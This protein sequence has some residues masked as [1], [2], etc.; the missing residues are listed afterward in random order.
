MQYAVFLPNFGPFGDAEA[1][2]ELARDAELKGW[3][4][5][6]IWDHIQLD[7]ADTGP[8]VDPWVA[9]TAIADATSSLRVGTMITPLARRGHGSS[10]ARR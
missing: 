1:L 2:I 8:I 4:G 5:F 7:G 3:D 10:R 9:L 6:F